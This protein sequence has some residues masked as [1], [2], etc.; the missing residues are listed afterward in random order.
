[1]FTRSCAGYC[2]ATFVLGI[3]DR[4]S[5]NILC[6]KDGRVSTNRLNIQP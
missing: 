4:H 6:A 5:E 1:V 3:G 2:I